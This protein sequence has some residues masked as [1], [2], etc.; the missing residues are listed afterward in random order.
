[1]GEKDC[2][3]GHPSSVPPFKSTEL[4]EAPRD[5]QI[6]IEADLGDVSEWEL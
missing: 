6:Q 1:M 5:E 2:I 4:A 3:S